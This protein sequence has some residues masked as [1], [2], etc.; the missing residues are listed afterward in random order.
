MTSMADSGL[1]KPHVLTFQGD[2][3]AEWNKF[4]MLYDTFINSLYYDKP[5]AAKANILLNLAGPEA[6]ERAKAFVYKNEVKDENGDIVQKKESSECVNDLKSKFREICNVSKNIIMDH[7]AFNTRNQKMVKDEKTKD[8]MPEDV[9][10]WVADLIYLAA[11]CEFGHLS[12]HQIHI[13][14]PD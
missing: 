3:A 8:E 7:H 12:D 14:Q 11:K 13:W 9:R 6:Q 5:E 4:E 2:K 1:N 10:K